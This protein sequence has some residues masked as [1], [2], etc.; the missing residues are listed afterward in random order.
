M[1]A[2]IDNND[3]GCYQCFNQ[4]NCLPLPLINNLLKREHT[5]LIFLFVYT[6]SKLNYVASLMLRYIIFPLFSMATNDN[7]SCGR[8]VSLSLLMQTYWNV[9]D[10][11]SEPFCGSPPPMYFIVQHLAF[12]LVI[13][14]DNEY[15][16][17]K[18]F[19]TR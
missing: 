16:C 9:I 6:V 12:C 11:H 8:S 5:I 17:I 13:V 4:Y 1:C 7:I 14:G 10:L 19:N 2:Q 15:M 18:V 3:F